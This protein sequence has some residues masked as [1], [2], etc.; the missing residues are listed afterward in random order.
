MTL[1]HLFKLFFLNQKLKFFLISL[2]L[3]IFSAAKCFVSILMSTLIDSLEDDYEIK[4]AYGIALISLNFVAVICQHQFYSLGYEYSTQVRINMS[5]I[6]YAKIFKLHP[7]YI[8]NTNQGKI[9]NMISADLNILE[10]FLIYMFVVFNLPFSL[11]MSGA[12]LWYRFDGPKGLLLIAI[13]LLIYPVQLILTHRMTL[14]I[15]QTKATAD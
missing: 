10:P 6:I 7:Y 3:F 4:Y 5:N 8:Q 1:W 12:V 13:L 14:Y 2:V 11:T 9:I 15:K